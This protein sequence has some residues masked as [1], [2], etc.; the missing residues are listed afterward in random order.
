M[1]KKTY[2]YDKKKILKPWGFEYTILRNTDKLSITYVN[3]LPNKQ[4]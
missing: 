3:I 1:K 2:N 4:T